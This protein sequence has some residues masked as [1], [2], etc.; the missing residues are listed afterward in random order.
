M[1]DMRKALFGLTFAWLALS[2]SMPTAHAECL[3][4][5]YDA[6]GNRACAQDDLVNRSPYIYSTPPATALSVI[7]SPSSGGIVSGGYAFKCP[8]GYEAV[9][10]S[11][12]Y[13]CARDFIEPNR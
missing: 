7:G 10:R 8:H 3:E 11:S 2:A 13:A 12:G 4:W 9:L 6:L 1:T 5:K